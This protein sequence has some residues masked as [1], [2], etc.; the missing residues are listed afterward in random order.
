[1]TTCMVLRSYYSLQLLP[2]CSVSLRKGS[3]TLKRYHLLDKIPDRSIR[4]K[5][6]R[7]LI[8]HE[9]NVTQ[10]IVRVFFLERSGKN[11]K[12]KQRVS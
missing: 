3:S 8:M 11:S 12:E 5:K 6:M 7:P 2:A 4:A 10:F 1:M 9:F